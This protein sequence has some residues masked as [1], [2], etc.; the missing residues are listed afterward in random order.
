MRLTNTEA[1]D[2]HIGLLHQ[3]LRVIGPKRRDYSGGKEPF[4][5]FYKSEFFGIPAWQG[6]LVRLSDKLSRLYQV[7]LK[8]GAGEVADESLIDTSGDAIN[9]VGLCLGL[10]IEAMPD[11]AGRRL[12]DKIISLRDESK[13]IEWYKGAA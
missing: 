9:Y 5:N 1:W 2:M 7:A 3:A 10:I 6:A 12:L 8:G 11:E 4:S 13:W